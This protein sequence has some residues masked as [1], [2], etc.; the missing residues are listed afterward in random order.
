MSMLSMAKDLGRS[1]IGN[2]K[3]AILIFGTGSTGSS[4]SSAAS[5]LSSSNI[6]RMT[7]Q[8]LNKQGLTNTSLIDTATA[9]HLEVQYNPASLQFMA[10]VDAVQLRNLQN[11]IAEGVTNQSCRAPSVTMSVDLIFN[12]VNPKDS[13]MADKIRLSANDIVTDVSWLVNTAKNGGYTVQPQSNGLLA[14]T[15][16]ETDRFVTFQWAD[17]SFSGE[18]TDVNVQYGMFSVSG[19]P[20]HSVVT[21]R[22]AQQLTNAAEDT[23]WNL[24]KFNECFSGKQSTNIGQKFGNLLNVT[25]F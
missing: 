23:Q 22:I 16:D 6:T 24:T 1:I 11:T 14:S 17:M 8:M 18:L 12:A 2:P 21:L 25:G 9:K 4:A 15:V 3:K 7:S 19:K 13:F 10:S 20:V 5:A